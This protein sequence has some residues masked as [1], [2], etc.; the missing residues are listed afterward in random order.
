[1]KTTMDMRLDGEAVQEFRASLRGALLRPGEEHYEAARQVWNGM[2]NRKPAFIVRCAGVAD[3]ISAINFARTYNLLVSVRGGGHNVTGNAVCDGGMM[4]DLSPMKGIHVDPVRRTARVEAGLTWGEFDQETQAFGLAMTGG[5]VSTTGIAGLTLGG[6]MGWLMR[7]CGLV[8][9]NLLSADIVTADGRLL[10]ASA[11]ENED[12]FWGIRGGGGNFGIA[13]SF[14]YRL[15]PIGPIVLGGMVLYPASQAKELL[16]FYRDYMTSAPDE[17]TAAPVFL[18]APPAP[19]IPAHLH[20]TPMVAIA[21]CY[22]GSIEAGQ[23]AVEPLRRFGP[24]A[25]DLLNPMPYTA[26]QRLFNDGVPFGQQAYVK[27][28]HLAGLSDAVI[29]TIVTHAATMTSPLSVVLIVPLGGAVSRVSKGDTAFGHREATYD[30]IAFSLWNDSQEAERHIQWVRDLGKAMQPF[31]IGV[32][33]NEIGNEGEERIRAAYPPA[34]Y[35]RLVAL[36]NKYDPAN[37]F[38]LNQNI[39]PTV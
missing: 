32:Y 13:T 23:G 6:G 12:L 1:M 16:H 37:L 38:H 22:A 19:F 20:A 2:I 10:T 18:T 14:K 25:L 34:T 21:A 4:I 3:V 17:L 9:D 15:H 5:M 28:D 7:K 31:S 27:S 36:K 8:I 33:V 29:D 39:K 26:I 30:Y 35:E 11:T 24:P